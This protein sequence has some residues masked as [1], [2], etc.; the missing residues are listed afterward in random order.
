MK[1]VAGTPYLIRVAGDNG[2]TGSFTLHID[3]PGHADVPI[4]LS[5]NFNGICNGPTEQTLPANSG[6]T[7]ENRCNLNGYRSIADKGL[8]CDPSVTDALNTGGTFGYQ[9]MSYSIISAPGLL[10]MVHLGNRNLAANSSRPFA[11]ACPAGTAS[12]VGVTPSWLSSADQTG[13]QTTVVS[14]LNAVFGPNTKLGIL[15]HTSNVDS[16][17]SLATFDTTL[18]FTDGSSTTVTV[19]ATDWAY[20]NGQTMPAPGA[21]SGLEQQHILGIY[22]AVEGTDQGNDIGTQAKV[23]EA[24]ISTT[25]L[26]AMG[27]NASGKTLASI[28]FGNPHSGNANHDPVYSGF[29]IFAATL[30]DPASYNPNFGPGGAGNLTPNPIVAGRLGLLA[31]NV[32]RGSGAPNA[33]TSL[34]VDATSIGLG[35]VQLNDSGSSGDIFAHDNVW[36][37]SIT[38]PFTA[39]V[40]AAA[41]PFTLTD[42]Q[43]PHRHRHHRLPD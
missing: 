27:F 38:P 33:I 35:I 37:A 6:T 25:A 30:R 4:Q 22:H 39:P 28:T 12:I 23:D 17:A 40:G 21:T 15:Y 3:D 20:N 7:Y 19:T 36:S 13:P 43:E 2:A 41:L 32:S 29:A 14:A 24:V 1:R 16:A 42:A 5:Y 26:S 11:S 34:S 31:V 9:G 18:G 8:Y 10:D